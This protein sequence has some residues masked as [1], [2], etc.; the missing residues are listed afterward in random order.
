MNTQQK[1]VAGQPA[2]ARHAMDGAHVIVEGKVQGVGFRHAARYEGLRLH[3]IGWVRNR[4]DGAVE[5]MVYGG[6][7]DLE[8]FRRF[9][10]VGPPHAR[11][12]SVTWDPVSTDE[13]LAGFSVL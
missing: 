8:A 5:I 11:V 2:R 12:S 3:L 4:D 13:P 1:E 7:G 6:S 9:V 10:E